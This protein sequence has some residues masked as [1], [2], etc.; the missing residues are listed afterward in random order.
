M[1]QQLA[2]SRTFQSLGFQGVGGLRPKPPRPCCKRG[3]RSQPSSKTQRQSMLR[4]VGHQQKREPLPKESSAEVPA[5][6]WCRAQTTAVKSSLIPRT[7]W[8]CPPKP[9]RQV[10]PQLPPPGSL[11][12]RPMQAAWTQNVCRPR[13]PDENH[14]KTVPEHV[15][16]TGKLQWSQSPESRGTTPRELLHEAGS[17]GIR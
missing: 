3:R 13:R 15:L 16:V 2:V 7:N 9:G 8:L 6:T 4:C 5:I 14:R 1:Q 11:P 17:T 10:P 12:F